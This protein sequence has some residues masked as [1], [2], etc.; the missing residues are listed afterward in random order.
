VYE[1]REENNQ[2]EK[3]PLIL[4]ADVFQLTN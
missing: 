1:K 3:H 4:Q 2:P